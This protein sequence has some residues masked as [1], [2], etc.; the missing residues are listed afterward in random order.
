MNKVK[1]VCQSKDDDGNI[2]GKYSSYPMLNTMVYDIDFPD[3]SIREY[4]ANV[5]AGNIYYQFYSEGFSH[6]IFSIILYFAKDTSAVQK[7]DQ[8]IITK[9]GQLRMQTS[10]VGWKLLISWKDGIGQ[11]IPLSVMK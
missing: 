5:I 9:L 3:G 7:G 4:R 2:I 8:Y 6:S 1:V 11:W 10:T